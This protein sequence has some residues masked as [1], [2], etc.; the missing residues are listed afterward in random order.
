MTATKHIYLMK[1]VGM[2]GPIKIGCSQFVGNRLA[3]IGTWSPFPLEIIYSAPGEHTLERNL[4]KCFADLHSHHEWFHPGARLLKAVEK[5]L[6]GVPIEEAIDLSDVRGSI[7]NYGKGSKACAPI[8]EGYR[9][10]CARI[11][12]AETRASKQMKR[13]LFA[14]SDV[15]GIIKRWLGF[16]E[17]RRPKKPVRPTEAEF[18]RLEEV[19]S[20][21]VAHF[22]TWEVKH[23]KPEL[24]EVAA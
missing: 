18:T 23:R 16:V 1:P 8:M 10:Y 21:P 19:L 20:D 7:L 14:P 24:V 17:Y 3:A 5:L 22:V 15:Q 4:H 6:A 13:R 2:A 12:H 11:R 9:S